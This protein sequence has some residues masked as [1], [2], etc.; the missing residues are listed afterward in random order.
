MTDP[1]TQGYEADKDEVE[2]LLDNVSGDALAEHDP[3]IRYTMLSKDSVLLRAAV[4]RL[5]VERA[6][7]VAAMHAPGGMSY[8]Q[9]GEALGLSKARA[10]QLVERGRAT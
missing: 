3:V 1:T 2:A 7:T 9:I 5:G 10:Q 4:D 6:R 8:S